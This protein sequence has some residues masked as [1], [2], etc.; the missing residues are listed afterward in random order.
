VYVKEVRHLK[1]RGRD[2]FSLFSVWSFTVSE[3]A[4]E[5]ERKQ[6]YGH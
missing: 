3:G 2:L 1:D 5:E 6:A 4:N